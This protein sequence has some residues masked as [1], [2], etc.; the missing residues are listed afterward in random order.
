MRSKHFIKRFN[1]KRSS[2]LEAIEHFK[3]QL[4][5][6]DSKP[7]KSPSLAREPQKSSKSINFIDLTLSFNHQTPNLSQNSIIS[8]IPIKSILPPL[9][10]AKK[11]DLKEFE[12]LACYSKRP[13]ILH[14]DNKKKTMSNSKS[15]KIK[16]A[17]PE[18]SKILTQNQER[19]KIHISNNYLFNSSSDSSESLVLDPTLG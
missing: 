12:D 18:N 19:K 14:Q 15:H 17:L 13:A 16:K 11:I 2:I 4:S 5:K 7:K 10:Q 8:N 3:Q 9:R 1:Y 6:L